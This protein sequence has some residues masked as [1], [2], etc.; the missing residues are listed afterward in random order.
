VAGEVAAAGPAADITGLRLLSDL[1]ASLKTRYNRTGALADLDEAIRAGGD[2]VAALPPGHLDRP[3]F[4]YNLGLALVSR[5]ERADARADIDQAIGLFGESLAATPDDHPYR[6]KYASSLGNVLRL[7]FDAG[8]AP[9]DLD[10]AIRIGTQAVAAALAFAFAPEWPGYALNVGIALRARFEHEGDLADLEQ[11]IRILREAVAATDVGYHE[12]PELLSSLGNALGD[13]FDRTRQRA[14]LEEAIQALRDAV[15]AVPENHPLWPMY[16][17]NLA[18]ALQTRFRSTKEPADLDTAVRVM[19]DSL[20]STPA[21][22][23]DWA[24]HASNLGAMLRLRYDLMNSHEDL[25]E[26]IQITREAMAGA[27]PAS[28]HRAFYAAN[29]GAALRTRFERAGR[30]ADHD[31]AISV[32]EEA[33]AASLTAPSIRIQAARMASELAAESQPAWA[34]QQLEQAVRLLPEVATRQ[35]ER[36]DQ[37]YALHGLSGL[38]ADAAA[39]T[40]ADP[41]KTP[42][43]RAVMALRLLETGRAVL[44]S[45]ALEI[46]GDVANLAEQ[47]PNLA[48]RFL[49]LRNQWDHVPGDDSGSERAPGGQR[50]L[51]DALS[52]VL[53]EIRTQPGFESFGQPPSE[54][55]LLRE[56]ADGAVVVLNVSRYRSDAILL[57]GDGISSLPLP[58]LAY[59]T[60]IS[61]VSTF[62]QALRIASQGNTSAERSAAQ[63]RLGQ[64]LR[65]LWDVVT[66]PVLNGLGHQTPPDPG[67]DMPRI[68]WV[69]GG[70]MSLLPLHAAGYH[71]DS[72]S[73]PGRRTVM[74]RVVSSYT[75]TIG[76]LRYARRATVTHAARQR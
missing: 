46:R 63:R 22:R 47:H 9:G 27:N 32:F 6:A 61:H 11:A 37:E 69:P 30:E 41:S 14:D 67:T 25:D 45:Q 75:P 28:Y 70:L 7:R 73:E 57:T 1:G 68:W 18:A 62:R 35:L 55:E 19:R 34:A 54:A 36:A 49:R 59:D 74:D 40:L 12:R 56:A 39:L 5:F 44:F 43:E 52:S 66:G 33:T 17:S 4:A 3:A 38:V 60:V 13:R 10:E 2:A 58:S 15:S 16:L 31:E 71:D 8:G 26:A 24:R 29:L 53:R 42:A 51:A 64:N 65:W 48:A 76:A 20:A 72:A 21:D 50:Q 23:P